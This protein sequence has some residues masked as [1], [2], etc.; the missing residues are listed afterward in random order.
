VTAIYISEQQPNCKL[1]L[2]LSVSTVEHHI[3][4]N[5]KQRY[6]KDNAGIHGKIMIAG[7]KAGK[8]SGN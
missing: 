4:N 2:K 5:K 3:G 1:L 8:H 6:S 7:N